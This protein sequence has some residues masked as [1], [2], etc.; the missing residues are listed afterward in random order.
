MHLNLALWQWMSALG[1]LQGLKSG[2][3]P[4]KPALFPPNPLMQSLQ[5]PDLLEAVERE[6]RKRLQSLLAGV[7]NYLNHPYRRTLEEPPAVWRAGSAR[8]LDY[9]PACGV[10]RHAPPLLLI[11]SLIN[12]YYILDLQKGRS[13]ARYLAESGYRPYIIDW[14]DPGPA[15]HSFAT[16]DY[17]TRYLLP[18][19]ETIGAERQKPVGLIGYCMGGLLALAAAQL[20]PQRVSQLSLLAT[21]WDFFSQDFPRIPLDPPYVQKLELLI[22]RHRTLPA[23]VVQTVFYALNPWAFNSKFRGFAH[24]DQQS[25]AADDFMALE[26]WVNHGVDMAQGV[27]KDCFLH[28]SQRNITMRGLW[29]VGGQ[30]INPSQI[31]V[32]AFIAMPENDH[33][34]PYHCAYPLARLMPQATVCQPAAGHVGMMVGS[35]AQQT[36]WQ[37]LTNWLTHHNVYA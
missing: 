3:T 28:W 6:A 31:R 2:F 33:I 35:Q 34:V 8:L 13:F 30:S 20:A 14:G 4:L 5:N 21:P 26:Q 29:Q 37:P 10:G 7:N 22:N 27:A 19:I 24:M 12:R 23:S 15:E 32:P 18:A 16:A 1:A 11:P 9:G 25:N 17:V 36:L